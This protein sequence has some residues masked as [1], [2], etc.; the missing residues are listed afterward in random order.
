MRQAQEACTRAWC[1]QKAIGEWHGVDQPNH[2]RTAE[3]QRQGFS[4]PGASTL[5]ALRRT[6]MPQPIV[7]AL[8]RRA[9]SRS[10]HAKLR[11]NAR[12]AAPMAFLVQLIQVATVD[13][14]TRIVEKTLP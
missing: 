3:R 2:S 14:L 6:R 12:E 9:A 4:R 1:S 5:D 8:P 10:L 13:R 11:S 7:R